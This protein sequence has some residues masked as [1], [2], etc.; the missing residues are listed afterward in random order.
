MAAPEFAGPPV[1]VRKIMQDAV[2]KRPLML[3]DNPA[4]PEGAIAPAGE[5]AAAAIV[6]CGLRRR[7]ETGDIPLTAANLSVLRRIRRVFIHA[8]GGAK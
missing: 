1:S 5:A 2:E 8:K 3:R 7:G 6:A 4:D